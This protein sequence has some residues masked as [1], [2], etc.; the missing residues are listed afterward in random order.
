MSQKTKKLKGEKFDAYLV[1]GQDPMHVFMTSI[2]GDRSSNEAVCTIEVPTDAIDAY[3]KEKNSTNPESKYTYL[4]VVSA[5]F[6]KIVAQRPAMNY[7][8]RDGKFY[9]R[10]EISIAC[11]AKKKKVDGAEEGLLII[12]YKKDETDSP[13]EQMHVKFCSQIKD[14][15]NT[16]GS[17]DDTMKTVEKLLSLPK[18]IYKLVMSLIRSLDK[19]GN[20]PKDLASVNPYLVTVYI[21]NLGSIGMDASYHHLI[22]FGTNSLFMIIGEKRRKP[23]FHEDGTFE[24]K[25]FLPISITVDER[26]SDGVYYSNSIRFFKALLMKPQLLDK[27]ANEE[28]DLKALA[29]EL[30]LYK[31]H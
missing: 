29:E 7:F 27:P 10:K 8:V 20:L 17:S 19:H 4:Q 5:A 9:E 28:I 26:I 15:R 3:L 1:P 18:P 24:L 14:F 12:R 21:S 11:N 30:N 31:K 13:I 23:V 16:E 2:M 22:N 25:D 6:S